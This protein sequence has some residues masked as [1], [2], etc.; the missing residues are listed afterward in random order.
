MRKRQYHCHT[1][2]PPQPVRE[3]P[4]AS[5]VG[6]YDG[7]KPVQSRFRDL[8]DNGYGG[9]NAYRA[10]R[11]RTGLPPSKYHV[12]QQHDGGAERQHDQQA[13]HNPIPPVGHRLPSGYSILPQGGVVCNRG[14]P[15]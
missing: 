7:D 10:R 6:N 12:A 5:I 15:S 1:P 3:T 14:V 2:R 8:V 13:P 4:C 9:G 11:L